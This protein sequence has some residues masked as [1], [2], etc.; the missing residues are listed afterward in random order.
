[1]IF[2]EESAGVG[3]LVIQFPPWIRSSKW[4][5]KYLENLRKQLSYIEE[6]TVAPNVIC[7]L[8]VSSFWFQVV[9]SPATTNQER[10]RPWLSSHIACGTKGKS[11]RMESSGAVRT[12]AAPALRAAALSPFLVS[13]FKFRVFPI[14]QIKHRRTSKKL[15]NSPF[16]SAFA[17]SSSEIWMAFNHF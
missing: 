9:P 13:R 16:T 14:P 11:E 1:V 15:S 5:Y 3:D 12:A 10:L 4:F 7:A 6:S 8:A 17:V 2:G